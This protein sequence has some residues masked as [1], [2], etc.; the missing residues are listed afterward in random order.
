MRF[1]GIASGVAIVVLIVLAIVDVATAPTPQPSQCVFQRRVVLPDICVSGC[2][3]P[4]QNC[5]AT[6]RPYLFFF[7]QS[8]TCL[9]GIICGGG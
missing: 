5:T 9:D 2:S 8:A 3:G 6:T 7:T 4:F 1:L